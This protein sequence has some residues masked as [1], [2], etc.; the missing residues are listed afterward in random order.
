MPNNLAFTTPITVTDL[1][2]ARIVN[3]RAID[4][5]NSTMEIEVEFRNL[6]TVAYPKTFRIIV[7]NGKVTAV[8]ARAAVVPALPAPTN[9]L[10]WIIETELTGAGVATAFDD[11]LAAFRTAGNPRNNVLSVLQGM[12]GTLPLSL[13]GG[14]A[15]VLPAGAVS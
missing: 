4:I 7:T 1:R 15:T 2:R 9:L 8:V 13:G 6:T 5:D 14:T 10:D 12:T 3:F 11:C